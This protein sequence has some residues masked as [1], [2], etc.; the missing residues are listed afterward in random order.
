MTMA[1]EVGELACP[2]CYGAYFL[3][4]KRW[5]IDAKSFTV[6]GDDIT[7]GMV[8]LTL[9]CAHCGVCL[10]RLNREWVWIKRNEPKDEN[11][12]Y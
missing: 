12:V 1:S 11:D 2:S 5:A 9:L 7:N 8:P 3:E 6:D 10:Q 4:P